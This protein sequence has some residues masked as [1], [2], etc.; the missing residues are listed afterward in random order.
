MRRINCLKNFICT[1][2]IFSGIAVYT[3]ICFSQTGSDFPELKGPWL[4][5]K[6]P[7]KTPELFAP[8]IISTKDGVE[9]SCTYTPDGNEFYFTRRQ[10]GGTNHVY[11]T[12]IKNG[13]W[14]KPE[15]A[16]FTGG[17]WA[18][19]PSVS[20]DGK[21]IFFG[22]KRPR[23][24]DNVPENGASIWYAERRGEYWK[25]PVY[26]GPGMMYVT[27]S[28]NGSIYY[29]DKSSGSYAK[30][31]LAWKSYK[32]NK[33]SDQQTVIIPETGLYGPAHPYITPDE[34]YLIY[35]KNGE[36]L[37]IFRKADGTWSKPVKFGKS[38]NTDVTENCAYVS[39]D[40]KYMF[41]SRFEEEKGT[42]NWKSNIYWV[43]AGIIEELK[44]DDLK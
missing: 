38:V 21:R 43:S 32:N 27:A 31:Y 10:Q 3:G 13:R 7:G 30:C 9:F 39:P 2:L 16:P 22:S 4:G 8:G 29:T 42:G 26:F 12:K 11:Y 17:F 37:I 44:P 1:I 5:Q 23:N 34:S 18:N 19:E 14:T 6:P 36:F 20:P 24:D 40:G 33:Y 15:I 28:A 35:D 41:F 25:N